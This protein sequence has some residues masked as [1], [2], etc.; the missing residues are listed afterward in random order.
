MKL[1]RC[2]IDFKKL[3]KRRSQ[4]PIET[5]FV[6]QIPNNCFFVPEQVLLQT[7]A[8]IPDNAKTTPQQGLGMER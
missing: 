5:Q 4:Q 3:I 7:N 2:T 1:S 8:E 6:K